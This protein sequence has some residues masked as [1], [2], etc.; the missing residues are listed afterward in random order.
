M[1]D[2]HVSTVCTACGAETGNLV[3]TREMM[4]GT[5]EPF[6]YFEC[7]GCGCLQLMNPPKDLSSYYPK[8][9][10]SFKA[11]DAVPARGFIRRWLNQTRNSGENFGHT[12]LSQLLSK[13]RPCVPRPPQFDQLTHWLKRATIRSFNVRVLDVG[14]GAGD[15][16]SWMAYIG[17]EHL[18]GVDPFAVPRTDADGRLRIL[19][20]TLVQ[21]QETDFDLVMSHHSLEHTADQFGTLTHMRR[22]MKD[23]GV[24]LVRIP[25]AGTEPWRR[26]RENWIELD[27]PRHL[28]IHTQRSFE[29]LV[30]KA[31]M[32]IE[33]AEFDE[34]GLGYWGSELY[35]A[36][37]QYVDPA[38][39]QHRGP[40]S[41]FDRVKVEEF[42]TR[43]RTANARRDG[44]R[45]AFY[46]RKA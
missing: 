43:A 16:L 15:L 22:V 13:L 3:H 45:A 14:C 4:Y 5:R 9:Y 28:V 30:E 10:Y 46:L 27:P 2:S 19:A 40:E 32:R 6:T 17:F 38:T 8:D 11:P 31:G 33:L 21:L 7:G 35:L 42:A 39:G 36:G 12:P 41:V 23:N 18:V 25:I 44:G 20:C 1:I 37:I 24:C 29:L 26:Y 34:T